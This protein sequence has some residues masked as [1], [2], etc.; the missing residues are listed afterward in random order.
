MFSFLKV[1]L[2]W[3]RYYIIFL[4]FKATLVLKKSYFVPMVS[5]LKY[6]RGISSLLLFLYLFR[7]WLKILSFRCALFCRRNIFDWWNGV[8]HGDPV[9]LVQ[10][11]DGLLVGLNN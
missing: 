8:D 4:K 1:C 11:D 2:F 7:F 6:Y 9:L 3:P 5:E 10:V